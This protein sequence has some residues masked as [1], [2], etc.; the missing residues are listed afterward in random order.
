MD[1]LCEKVIWHEVNVI[2][3]DKRANGT[4]D[5]NSTTSTI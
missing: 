4:F 1:K 2:A 5:E 3:R